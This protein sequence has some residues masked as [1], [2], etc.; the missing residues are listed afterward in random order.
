MGFPVIYQTI[1]IDSDNDESFPVRLVVATDKSNWREYSM[2]G[3][4]GDLTQDDVSAGDAFADPKNTGKAIGILASGRNH[5]LRITQ[6]A[7]QQQI[8]DAIQE[9][10]SVPGSAGKGGS[11]G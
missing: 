7:T 4:E 11:R 9:L 6:D 1:Y 3:E 5:S 8:D 10:R 2:F